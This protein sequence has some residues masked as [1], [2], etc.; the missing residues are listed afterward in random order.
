MPAHDSK[1]RRLSVLADEARQ[2]GV[3]Y[4]YDTEVYDDRQ[5]YSMLLKVVNLLA[6]R[7]WISNCVLHVIAWR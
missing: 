7:N 2:E 3:E 4:E 1:R 5:F 6:C